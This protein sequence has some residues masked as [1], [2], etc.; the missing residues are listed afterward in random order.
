MAVRIPET[1]PAVLDDMQRA[2]DGLQVLYTAAE[3]LRLAPLCDSNESALAVVEE[4]MPDDAIR[5]SADRRHYGHLF[6]DIGL[7]ED[8]VTQS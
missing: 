1:A 4:L 7:L 5:G 2:S 6:N 3:A 8:L